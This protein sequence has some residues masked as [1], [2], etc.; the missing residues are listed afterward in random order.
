M[1]HKVRKKLRTAKKLYSVEPESDKVVQLKIQL[2]T[3]EY[4]QIDLNQPFPQK[5]TYISLSYGG[6]NYNPLID[7]P[8]CHYSSNDTKTI[9]KNSIGYRNNNKDTIE[10]LIQ[11]ID[12]MSDYI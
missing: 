4:V 7:T 5:V 12:E 9:L 6:F 2:P 10:K 11:L 8:I 1:H 3:N